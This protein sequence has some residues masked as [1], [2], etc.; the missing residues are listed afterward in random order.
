M[1]VRKRI[2]SA[3]AAI[4]AHSSLRLGPCPITR[5]DAIGPHQAKA[6]SSRDEPEKRSE[7][8]T[9]PLWDRH[10]ATIPS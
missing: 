3:N 2:G 6:K 5:T 1:R 8:L 9:A 7:S 4:L 10:S